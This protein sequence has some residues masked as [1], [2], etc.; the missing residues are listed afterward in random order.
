LIKFSKKILT[1]QFKSHLVNKK[2]HEKIDDNLINE[3]ILKNY[4][5]NK[6]ISDKEKEKKPFLISDWIL[7]I[8]KDLN[9][10]DDNYQ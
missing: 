9:I 7:A 6:F 3:F 4:Y 5:H 1:P 8:Q 10:F 2:N